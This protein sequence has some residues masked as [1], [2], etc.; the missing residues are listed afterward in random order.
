MSE[1][2]FRSASDISAFSSFSSHL[3]EH[4]RSVFEMNFCERVRKLISSVFLYVID[5]ACGLVIACACVHECTFACLHPP[6]VRE[7]K[8]TIIFFPSWW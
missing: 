4:M 5:C 1:K 2:Y 3:H 8:V 6:P 7:D